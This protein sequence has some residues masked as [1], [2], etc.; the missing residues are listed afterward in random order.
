MKVVIDCNVIVSAALAGGTCREVVAKAIRY[1]EIILSDPIV[2]EY[3]AISRRPKHAHYR[4]H[5][6][7]L[8][9]QIHK[10]AIV[11]EPENV[12][13]GLRDPDDEV[14]LATA[15]TG[16]AAVITGNT[17]DFTKP[18]YGPVDILS[19]RMFLDQIE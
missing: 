12:T 13:F 8:V 4:D 19:P 10:A 1:H 7:N 9:N 6:L 14:Y 16:G 11:V 5:L 15:V 3:M 18:K 2:D 17:K